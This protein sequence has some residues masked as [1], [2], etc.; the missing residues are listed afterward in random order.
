MKRTKQ[1]LT[2]YLAEQL[3][4][5]HPSKKMEVMQIIMKNLPTL[6]KMKQQEI[7]Q[8]L[9]LCNDE[10]SSIPDSGNNPTR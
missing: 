9:N 7:Q 10:L 2:E 3:K 4:I 1:A 6:R 5:A 8:L